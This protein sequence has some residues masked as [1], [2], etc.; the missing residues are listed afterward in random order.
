MYLSGSRVP[1]LLTAIG[2]R[3]VVAI[4]LEI[5]EEICL[6]KTCSR[7]MRVEFSSAIKESTFCE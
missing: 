1:Q 6:T 4:M 7:A 5:V 3:I 2:L